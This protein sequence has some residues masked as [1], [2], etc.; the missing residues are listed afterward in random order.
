MAL[1]LFYGT[2]FQSPPKADGSVNA[3]GK[4]YFYEPGTSTPKDTYT[5]SDLSVANPNPL[6]LSSAGRGTAWLNGA[7]KIRV[8]DADDVLI[9]EEDNYNKGNSFDMTAVTAARTMVGVDDTGAFTHSGTYTV[10]LTQASTLGSGWFTRHF[11]VGTGVITFSRL[12]AG[13]TINGSAANFTLQPGEEVLIVVNAGTTGFVVS[14]TKPELYAVAS[15]TDTYTCTFA[16]AISALYSGQKLRVRFTN[17]NTSTTPTLNPNGLGAK[18]IKKEG[19]AALVAG[20]IPAGHEAELTYNGTDLILGNPRTARPLF[21]A[22]FSYTTTWTCP[23]GVSVVHATVVGGG[24]GGGGGA[25]TTDGGGGGGGGGMAAKYVAVTAG[26]SYT[27]TVGTGGNGGNVGGAGTNGSDSTAF[28][29]TGGG[30]DNGASNGIIGTGGAGTSGDINISGNSGATNNG[31]NG[32]SGGFAPIYHLAGISASTK[33][34]SSVY[35]FGA[36]GNGG[37]ENVVGSAGNAGVVVIDC[38]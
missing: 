11:N 30:G 28:G 1:L 7:Y 14:I 34:S 17:A 38:Y 2:T 29:I 22:M 3:G 21:S 36:G 35:I 10:S 32:G 8:T 12:A 18:T 4:V 24:G 37:N 33:T 15:G 20:D 25:A 13:D 16:P 27:I 31:V 6:I 23:T 5:T 19:S 9:D 26:A